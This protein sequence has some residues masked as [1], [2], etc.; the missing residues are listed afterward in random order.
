MAAVLAIAAADIIANDLPT[1]LTCLRVVDAQ[2]FEPFDAFFK[3]ET[4][5]ALLATKSM[6][7]VDSETITYSTMRV[8]AA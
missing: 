1:L 2:L 3:P 6:V 7:S 5:L 4:S 8:H